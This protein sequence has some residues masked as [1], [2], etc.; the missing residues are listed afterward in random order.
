MSNDI[1]IEG[2]EA[3]I[4]RFENMADTTTMEKAINKATLLVERAAKQNAQKV[5]TEENGEGLAGSIAS[6]VEGLTGI[7]FTPLFFAPYYEYGTGI[8]AKHPTKQGR[9][10]VPWVYVA[11]SYNA[12][13]V[14]KSYTLEEAQKAVA[15]L[16][17][18][19]L[20]ARYTYGMKPQPFLRPALDENRE[21]IKEILG[22]GLLND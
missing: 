7:V 9:Q 17:G 15:F 22:E 21:R 20:D 12:N 6:K 3:V 13:P 14:Q 19:G 11:G 16:K 5:N 2:L 1:R 18:K 4:E 10:D 8:E